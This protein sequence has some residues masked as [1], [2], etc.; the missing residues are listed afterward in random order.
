VE[1]KQ[2]ALDDETAAAGNIRRQFGQVVF[3]EVFRFAAG[4]AQ[5]QMLVLE[6]GAEKP[7]TGFY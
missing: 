7:T 1:L 4:G 6:R 2:V 5:Q 3:V